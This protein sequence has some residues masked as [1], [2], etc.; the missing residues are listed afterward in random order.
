MDEEKTCPCKR[1][2]VQALVC[3]LPIFLWEIDFLYGL[4]NFLSLGGLQLLSSRSFARE[5]KGRFYIETATRLRQYIDRGNQHFARRE[6]D[7]AVGT[8]I[9]VKD[10]L[11]SWDSVCISNNLA[12]AYSRLGDHSL[13]R[14]YIREAEMLVDSRPELK[15]VK[16]AIQSNRRKI[17]RTSRSSQA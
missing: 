3:L 2:R 8:W 1:L 16:R 5:T 17:E 10:F 14:Q 4:G 9:T 6:Y 15:G 13:A 11:G 12:C 7:E